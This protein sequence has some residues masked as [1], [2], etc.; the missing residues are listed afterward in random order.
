M[1]RD[2]HWPIVAAAKQQ[3]GASVAC[4]GARL[5]EEGRSLLSGD[6]ASPR[7]I[8]RVLGKHDLALPRRDAAHFRQQFA[9]ERVGRDNHATGHD[10]AAVGGDIMTIGRQRSD[11]FHAHARVQLNATLQRR[12]DHAADIL[13][14][15]V[16]SIARD[17]P[18]EKVG[19]N[20]EFLEDFLP[21]PE[22]DALAVLG[23][24]HDFLA[25]S[26]FF[27][28]G[29]R[30]VEP[31]ARR[32]IAIDRFVM[33]D[34]L[35]SIAVAKGHSQNHRRLPFAF[36]AEN[37]NRHR[38]VD[39]HEI[40]K[41]L[42]CETRVETNGILGNQLEVAAVAS[43][44]FGGGIGAID[45]GDVQVAI[46]HSRPEM[47]GRRCAGQPCADDQDIHRFGQGRCRLVIR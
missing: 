20:V 34:L 24:E 38:R 9:R 3:R 40:A 6:G 15:M 21:W 43:A 7:A 31:S 13:E 35:K 12:A 8:E 18:P 32:K 47:I 16:C 29:V 26:L 4:F 37:F 11:P 14:G 25:N 28:L 22:L 46:A 2:S 42:A 19:A 5:I 41:S 45:D 36:G 27:A 44:G 1:K 10:A 39:P 23:A 17:E 30:E 33:D